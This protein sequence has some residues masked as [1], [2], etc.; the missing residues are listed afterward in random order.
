MPVVAIDGVSGTGKS[1]VARAVARSLGV[2]CL[3]TGAMYRALGL[4][5][6]RRGV[7]LNDERSLVDL[8]A[9]VEID[10]ADSAHTATDA[11]VT[12]DGEDVSTEI[13]TPDA[14]QSA[15]TVAVH[16]E[17]RR[18][19]VEKQ[20]DWVKERGGAVVEGRDIGSVVLPEADVKAYL[21]ASGGER[22]RR[23]AAQLGQGGSIDTIEADIAVRDERDTTR[24]ADP[25]QPAQGALVIDTTDLS[26]DE[27]VRLILGRWNGQ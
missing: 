22:A 16:P 9:V 7:D 23:R 25:L 19:L 14:G 5:A 8:L 4:A 15:I 18:I 2:P 24:S 27:V 11:T 17:V 6:T 13:R 20:R 1:S 12:L 21:T 26:L 10:I 3:D